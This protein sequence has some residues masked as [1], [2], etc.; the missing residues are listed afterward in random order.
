M[1]SASSALAPTLRAGSIPWLG[2]CPGIRV[3]GD[4]VL[5]RLHAEH[6]ASGD[7]EHSGISVAMRQQIRLQSAAH[8]IRA[9]PVLVIFPHNQCNCRCVMCDIWRIR[10]AQE[11]TPARSRT[12]TDFIPELGVRWV[13]FSGGEPQLNEK[14]S[15]LGANASLGGKP[16][17]SADG[18]IVAEDLKRRSSPTVSTTSS[19]LSTARRQS[20]T[21]FAAFRVHLSK[22]RRASERLRHIRPDMPV[23]ARCTVQKANHHRF[24]QSSSPRKRSD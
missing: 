18:R 21:A 9:L 7:D 24:A 1:G 16:R 14:W 17:H 10:E 5:V 15:C 22:W 2:T 11:I 20:T 23:R 6:A 8:Q 4:H 19:S 12:A 13:V 3:L